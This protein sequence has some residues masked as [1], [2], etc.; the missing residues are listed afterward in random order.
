MTTRDVFDEFTERNY[1]PMYT[2][3]CAES[4]K[5]LKLQ[6]AVYVDLHQSLN[7]SLDVSDPV[8]DILASATHLRV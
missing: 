2:G 3:G 4:S 7:I 1:L 6:Q 5:R 8:L